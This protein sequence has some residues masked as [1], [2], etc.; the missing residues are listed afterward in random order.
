MKHTIVGI[1]PGLVHT[2]VVVLELLPNLGR[3]IVD[4]FTIAGDKHADQV[5]TELKARR[6]NTKHI[7][8]ESYRERGT[9]YR[10]NPKMRELLADFRKRFPKASIIDNTGVKKI[11]GSELLKV[12]GLTDFPTTHHQ[13]LQAAARI[14]VYGMLKDDELN[15]MLTQVVTDFVD[16]RPWTIH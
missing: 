12:L 3:I 7:F 8:I 11:V 15:A 5:V 2:G 1:D 9:S 6:V 16:G 10:T 4:H 14:L 13:D